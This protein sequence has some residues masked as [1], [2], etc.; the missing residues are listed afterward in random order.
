MEVR[1]K[2]IEIRYYMFIQ[3]N[4]KNRLECAYNIPSSSLARELI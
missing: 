4:M 2:Y 1:C 3:K